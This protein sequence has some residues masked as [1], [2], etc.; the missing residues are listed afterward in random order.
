M[1]PTSAL[2]LRE[3]PPV[4][5]VHALRE[6]VDHLL[7]VELAEW[8][9]RVHAGRELAQ[10]SVNWVGFSAVPRR[11]GNLPSGPVPASRHTRRSSCT[12]R[13][14]GRRPRRHRRR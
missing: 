6:R 9:L 1:G 2:A 13:T 14:A 5:G 12:R 8:L 4:H 10:A 3:A 7:R 11:V